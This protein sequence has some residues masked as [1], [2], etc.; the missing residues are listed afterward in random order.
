MPETSY[1]VQL[2]ILATHQRVVELATQ[3]QSAEASLILLD[4]VQTTLPM[5]RYAFGPC[6]Q[7][8]Y[9]TPLTDKCDPFSAALKSHASPTTAL[10]SVVASR[11]MAAV[12]ANSSLESVQV[13]MT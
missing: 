2:V 12:K 6:D 9:F 11:T 1:D 8:S 13:Q 10:D 4:C 3:R 5:F 7:I